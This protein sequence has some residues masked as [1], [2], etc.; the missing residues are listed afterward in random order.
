LLRPTVFFPDRPAGGFKSIYYLT[1][2]ASLPLFPC[3]VL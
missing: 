3:V 1:L 2:K